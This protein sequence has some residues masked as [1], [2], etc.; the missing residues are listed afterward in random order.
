M[1]RNEIDRGVAEGDGAPAAPAVNFRAV[2]DRVMEKVVSD[3]S[4]NSYNSSNCQFVKWL[5]FHDDVTVRNLI[6]PRFIQQFD[7]AHA[8]DVEKNKVNK[9]IISCKK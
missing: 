8:I 9:K 7:G 3:S 4:R 2:I 6:K 1:N 5:Y